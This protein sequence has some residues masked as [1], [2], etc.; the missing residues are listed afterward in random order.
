MKRTALIDVFASL[1]RDQYQ[2]EIDPAV[3]ERAGKA[4]REMLK[5]G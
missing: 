5:Y 2:I 3:M 1:E 4:L